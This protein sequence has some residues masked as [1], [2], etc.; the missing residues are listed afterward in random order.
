MRLKTRIEKILFEDERLSQKR[1]KLH[2]VV[3]ALQ[4]VVGMLDEH[5]ING[6]SKI[7]IR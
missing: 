4:S 5:E 2:G 6:D 3:H 1:R 7:A